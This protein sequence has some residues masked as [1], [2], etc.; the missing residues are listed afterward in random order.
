M[1]DIILVANPGEISSGTSAK[2]VLQIVAPTNQRLKIKSWGIFCKGISAT[3]APLRVRLL[4]QTTAGTMSALTLVKRGIATETIQSSAQHTATAEPTAGD[5]LAIR[6]VHPQ[7][8][9][10]EILS[11]GD[12]IKVPGG[13]RVGIEVLAGVSISV[14]P[15]IVFE[16]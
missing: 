13:G 16:E 6:E 5:I 12:E 15:E 14:V 4:R 11:P 10:Y 3:D 2:T 7:G 9:Y 1:S 8:G